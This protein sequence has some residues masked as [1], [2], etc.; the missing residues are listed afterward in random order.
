[1]RNLNET[2]SFG[3]ELVKAL[4]EVRQAYRN[5]SRDL[6]KVSFGVLEGNDSSLWGRI[7]PNG[8]KLISEYKD[9]CSDAARVFYEW[10]DS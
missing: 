10:L 1:M 2:E 9:T 7:V 5:F 3:K 6:S 8:F 4:K